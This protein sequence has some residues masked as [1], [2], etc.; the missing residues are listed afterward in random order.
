LATELV[1]HVHTSP[2]I[3]TRISLAVIHISL[4]AIPSESCGAD[5]FKSVDAVHTAGIV[6]ARRG[7]ALIYLVLTVN[8]TEP[9][10][11]F[12]GVALGGFTAG[13]PILTGLILASLGR[14]LTVRAMPAFGTLTM[15]GACPI[16]LE[17]EQN[18]VIKI[19]S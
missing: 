4:T 18:P 3:Q 1:H 11:T 9:C 8:A 10:R 16:V 6:F 19:P 13:R 12:T 7:S 17:T 2:S 5:A 15:V 14:S